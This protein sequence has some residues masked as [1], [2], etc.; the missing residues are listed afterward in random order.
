MVWIEWTILFLVT[1][2]ATLLLVPLVSKLAIKLD[3]VDYPSARRVNTRPV[4]RLGGVAMVGAMAVALAVYILGVY[5]L[6]WHND[7]LKFR[8]EWS[9]NV[10]GVALGVVFM[11]AV[12]VVDDI[13]QLKPKPK[14][15]GQIV[16]ACIVAGS[17]LLLSS[18]HNPLPAGGYVELGIWAYPIT[19][20]YLVAF[21]N[22]INLIDG[23]DGL[24]AGITSISVITIFVLC[25]V[26]NALAA[27]MLSVVLLGACLGFLRYNFNPASIFMGDSGALTLG[28]L[29]G[30]I[31]LFGSA[32]TA[33]LVSLLVPVIAAGVPIMDTMVAIIR[34]KRAHRPIGEADKGHIHHRLMQAGFS[35][36][37][38][39]LI[40]W[41]WTAALALCALIMMEFDGPL[42]LG[43]LLVVAG[44]TAYGILRLKLVHP[45]L[46]HQY[47]PRVR[48]KKRFT[49]SVSATGSTEK[50]ASTK[51]KEDK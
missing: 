44:L 30:I 20:F 39:V 50:D 40:M 24:A 13:V 32:R 48:R 45:A 7:F 10:P 25:V 16:A 31:S 43:A 36:R 18:F 27:A 15:L 1:V 23:L 33:M 6:G 4:P 11:F 19:V 29:L 28:F 17:G 14:L 46:M 5:L 49:G 21:A 9:V 3:A 37:A 22:I 2:L 8:N 38:T 35:Q 47:A 26:T 42:R 34:R 12:G 51:T 41:A